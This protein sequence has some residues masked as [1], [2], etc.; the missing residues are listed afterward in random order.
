[1]RP[2]LSKDEVLKLI[3]GFNELEDIKIVEFRA[4]RNTFEELYKTGDIKNIVSLLNHY[5][6]LIWNL[7]LKVRLFL[8]KIENILKN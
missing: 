7:K 6:F 4:R 3:D 2:V 1:M 8:I 5:M